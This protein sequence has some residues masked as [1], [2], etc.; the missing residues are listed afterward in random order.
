MQMHKVIFELMRHFDL[1]LV[2]P[3]KPW[4]ATGTRIWV[5]EDFFAQITK[6]SPVKQKI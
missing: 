4:K 5:I 3:A 1:S 2:D 6:R